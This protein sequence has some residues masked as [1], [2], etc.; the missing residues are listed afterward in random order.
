[1]DIQFNFFLMEKVVKPWQRL[2]SAV[3][4]GVTFPGRVKKAVLM[5]HLGTWIG[6]GLAVLW[7]RLN[8]V[9]LEVFSTLN[10]SMTR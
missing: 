8:S 6:G 7:Q 2:P 1:M 5:W 4:G 9:I 10:D 3:V